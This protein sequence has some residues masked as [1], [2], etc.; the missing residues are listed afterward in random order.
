MQKCRQFE[1]FLHVLLS[2]P[3]SRRGFGCV[4]R[5]LN[6]KN[7]KLCDFPVIDWNYAAYFKVRDQEVDGSNR[8]APTILQFFARSK[9]RYTSAQSSRSHLAVSGAAVISGVVL[10]I[11]AKHVG[12]LA[13]LV[14]YLR[15]RPR[16]RS[17]SVTL[18]RR[19]SPT[20]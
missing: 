3:S 2:F 10:L 5:R 17:S 19:E 16:H 7:I 12:L 15:T 4:Y 9:I 13:A 18:D 11:I 14:R 6:F 20:P 1:R 8:L